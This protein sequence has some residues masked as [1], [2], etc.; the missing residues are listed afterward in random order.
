MAPSGSLQN[1]SNDRDGKIDLTSTYGLKTKA[2]RRKYLSPVSKR[3]KLGGCSNEQTSR[4]AFS[5]SMGVDLEKE[6]IKHPLTSSNSTATAVGDNFQTK[7]MVSCSTKEKACR[8]KMATKNSLTNDGSNEKM[9]MVKLENKP[10]ECK[11]DTVLKLHSKIT[12]GETKFA[13]E[14]AQVGTVISLNK[15][16]TADIDKASG[17][18]RITSSD[19]HGGIK[20][21]EAPSI[22]DRNKANDPSSEETEKRGP[23]STQPEPANN[24]RR[25]GTR[26]RPP[27]A[28]ALEAVAFGFLGSGKRKGDPKNAVINRPSQRARKATKGCS[29]AASDDTETSM[30]TT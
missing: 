9:S 10:S 27:T 25:H 3:R 20:A 16:E 7:I 13:K 4:H 18:M 5:F 6:K 15:Q 28:K 8:Q 2:E 11:E 26:N 1:T 19:N 22:S 12:V 23:A 29:M 17:S 14:R 21:D 24:P 30:R